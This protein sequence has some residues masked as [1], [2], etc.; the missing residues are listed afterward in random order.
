MTSF[1][2]NEDPLGHSI[3]LI[4]TVAQ[5]P[6]IN[7]NMLRSRQTTFRDRMQ[8]SKLNAFATDKHSLETQHF[9]RSRD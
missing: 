2:I 1:N 8:M 7:N 4:D 6:V 3:R 5:H 9:F